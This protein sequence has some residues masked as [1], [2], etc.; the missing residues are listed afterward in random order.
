MNII[1]DTTL[2]CGCPSLTS[3]HW[4]LSFLVFSAVQNIFNQF[5]EFTSDSRLI[6]CL[7]QST[8]P[9]GIEPY[10]SRTF[11]YGSLTFLKSMDIKA[12][13]GEERI[14]FQR[15][16]NSWIIH[17]WSKQLP[18]QSFQLSHEWTCFCNLT[19]KKSVFSFIWI[20]IWINNYVNHFSQLKSEQPAIIVMLIPI[21]HL[22]ILKSM[23]RTTNHLSSIHIYTFQ[24]NIIPNQM[25]RSSKFKTNNLSS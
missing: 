10:G 3:K 6:Y 9:Y 2:P 21:S 7:K 25:S 20:N 19:F 17:D 5:N 16:C 13:L 14:F 4:L 12:L 22:N 18:L 15:A 24:S 11:S 1:G 23:T 8:D